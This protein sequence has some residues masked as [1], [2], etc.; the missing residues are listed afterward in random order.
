M[1]PCIYDE[2]MVVTTATIPPDLR[3][4]VREH[5]EQHGLSA[6]EVYRRAVTTYLRR[7][8]RKRQSV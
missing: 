5:A 1:R 4:R 3:D 8:E 2:P 7:Q 6:S